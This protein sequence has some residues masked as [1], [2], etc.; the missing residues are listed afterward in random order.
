MRI[1]RPLVVSCIAALFA[2]LVFGIVVVPAVIAGAY[3]ERSIPLLNRALQGRTDHTLAFYQSTW[4]RAF[5]GLTI[6]LVLTAVVVALVPWRRL[7]RRAKAG[8]LAATQR[9]ISAPHA[10][11]VAIATG[12]IFGF[13]EA[14]AHMALSIALHRPRWG[15]AGE[16]YTDGLLWMTPLANAAGYVLLALLLVLLTRWKL[17]GVP[18]RLL[19]LM[20]TGI[21]TYGILHS[22][23]TG[24]HPLAV[25]LVSAG[26]GW[27]LS[28]WAENRERPLT[29]AAQ[30]AVLSGAVVIAVI[31]FA[32]A[33]LPRSPEAN[34][35]ARKGWNVLLLIL[36]TQ[37]A[38][39]LGVYGYARNTSPNI[40]AFAREAAVFEKA[41]ATAPW[42]L[43]SHASFFTGRWPSELS[44]SWNV[45]LDDQYPTV[46]EIFR[47]RGYAT[48]GF[49][50]NEIYTSPRS[51]LGRGFQI[52][53]GDQLKPVTILKNAW[54]TRSFMMRVRPDPDH[55]WGRKSAA[56][57]RN[58]FAGWLDE[59]RGASFFA[60]L[61]FMDT[62]SPYPAPAPFDTMFSGKHIKNRPHMAE[63]FNYK[64]NDLR[65]FVDAY[66][67][68][69]AYTDAEIG[70]LLEDLKHR[71]ELDR[72]I[73]IITADHG[74]QLGERNPQL[75][76][77]GNSL[78]YSV[79]H[80]PLIIRHPGDATARGRFDMPVSLRDLPATMLAMAGGESSDK[81]IPGSSLAVVWQRPGAAS[82]SPPLAQLTPLA[83]QE[84][85]WKHWG[86]SVI[87]G[88]YHYIRNGTDKEELYDVVADPWE[89]T[90]LLKQGQQ[91][92]A[93]MRRL[94]QTTAW[95]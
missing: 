93:E 46:A 31:A 85:R 58:E 38:A 3:A 39:N 9:R 19:V 16:F 92:P 54:L 28:G 67:Q 80:V 55:T 89:R 4:N 47:E 91:V 17:R 95:R 5:M 84:K 18:V 62:H 71:G 87:S 37:R 78:Y 26:I 59:I 24:L 76:L 74:E 10:L 34:R 30:R 40:D 25:L 13:I 41:I 50:A 56:D 22:L 48:G 72:T 20:L 29:P 36:D 6:A 81:K 94:V 65:H 15:T 32:G 79:L 35:P 14:A 27:Q 45:R 83:H 70:K 63:R 23:F 8:M 90:D 57:V 73:V 82:M 68:S 49:V 69:L 33:A 86:Q 53:R 7:A 61:N 11:V 51:G 44:T 64:G 60:F 42:T 21:G 66:D 88:Q 12:V 75:I 2:W 52:Y 77:H 1:R 43:A